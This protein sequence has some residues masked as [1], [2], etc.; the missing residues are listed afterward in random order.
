[1]FQ[2][3]ITRIRQRERPSSAQLT[4]LLDGSPRTADE[5]MARF[6]ALGLRRLTTC[7]LTRN[8]K[9]MV[10]FGG[11]ELRVHAGYLGAPDD[12]LAAIVTFVE[13][14]TR[15]QRLCARRQLLAF[16]I[17]TP[18]TKRRRCATHAA[19]VAAAT[20]LTEWHARF[21][22]THFGGALRAVDVRVSRR[23]RARL[24]HYTAATRDG[25]PPEIAISRRHLRRHGWDE[26][27]RTLLHEMVHQWQDECGLG[28]DHGRTFRAKAREVGIAPQAKRTF[29]A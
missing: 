24:G 8:R 13:G 11:T 28:I 6:T 22:G 21:N 7:R 4:L 26:A 29:A 10:S 14:R 9:V 12:I 3:L 5:L 1:M 19:D 23:M 20:R 27:L 17:E 18:G 15:A 25:D 16:P 2:S